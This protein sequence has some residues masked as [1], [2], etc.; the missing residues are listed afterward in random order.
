MN[1]TQRYISEELTHFVAKDES[2]ESKQYSCL[3]KI[4]HEG[5]LTHPPHNPDISGNLSV[6]LLNQLSENKIYNPQIICF[7]DIPIA[8][9]EIHWRKYSRF[10]ISFSKSFL[11]Q[12]GANPVFYISK[13]SMI[14][15]PLEPPISRSEYFDKK[16]K[17]YID[18]FHG[19]H[20]LK[21]I[22]DGS[23][24]IPLKELEYGRQKMEIQM[25]LAFHLFSFIKFYDDKLPENHPDNFYMEREWRKL[26]NLK[27]KIEDV[28]R[29]FLPKTYAKRFR[30]DV[31]EYFGQINFID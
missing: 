24:A 12:N 7:C 30:K 31:P 26:G 25:F 28:G 2:K 22:V 8:D 20:E 1:R 18:F 29:V 14:H 11:I 9:I 5:W 27:F 23:E 6:K 3:V 17:Q 21:S 13:N 15:S 16:H 4:F 19:F 10:G